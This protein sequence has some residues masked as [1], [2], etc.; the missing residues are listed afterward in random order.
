MYIVDFLDGFVVQEKIILIW[1]IFTKNSQHCHLR[2][3][4]IPS[5]SPGYTERENEKGV[6]S[7][8]WHNHSAS[9]CGFGHVWYVRRFSTTAYGQNRAIWELFNPVDPEEVVVSHKICW[10]KRGRLRVMS[11][12]NQMFYYIPLIQSYNEWIYGRKL[13]S[14]LKTI[15]L[16]SFTIIQILPLCTSLGRSW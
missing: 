2:G 12:R 9:R 6:W 1:N 4:T 3:A 15:V 16:I 14:I 10:V 13:T 8:S 11:I 5:C 7:E